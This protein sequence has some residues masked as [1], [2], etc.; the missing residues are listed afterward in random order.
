M[1]ET[2]TFRRVAVFC[3][4]SDLCDP[5]YRDAAR[6]VGQSL[7]SKGIGVVYG[8]GRVGTMGDVAD[9]AL[10]A[11]GEVYGVIPEKLQAL[12]VGHLELTQ[13]YVVESMH[14]RKAMMA[15]LADG[16]IALPGG[17]GTLDELFEALTWTQLN[18][19]LK[20]V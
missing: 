19:H 15:Q 3:G 14:A 4:S 6:A 7:A 17:Y 11:G 10:R 5:V 9:A 20:P 18:Y 13:L 12:E 1:N 2:R 8:G 16:F